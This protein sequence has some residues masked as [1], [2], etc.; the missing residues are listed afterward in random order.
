MYDKWNT[1]SQVEGVIK[2]EYIIAAA[3]QSIFLDLFGLFSNGTFQLTSKVDITNGLKLH[4][5][6]L[7]NWIATKYILKKNIRIFS[8]NIR[9]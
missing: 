9:E 7:S 6:A 8:F 3:V 2:L 4:N 1:E 5:L